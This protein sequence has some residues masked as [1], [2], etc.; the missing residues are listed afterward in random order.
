MQ[1]NG[2][3]CKE[4]LMNISVYVLV[5]P[6]FYAQLRSYTL[7]LRECLH[8]GLHPILYVVLCQMP[9]NFPRL[10]W[11]MILAMK[12]FF[13]SSFSFLSRPMV[14]KQHNT[15]KTPKYIGSREQDQAEIPRRK[16]QYHLRYLNV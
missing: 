10:K 1:Y 12:P 13:G 2:K 16:A 5:Y 9:Q 4:Y 3:L 6:V 8:L 7:F 14:Q 15:N 11:L